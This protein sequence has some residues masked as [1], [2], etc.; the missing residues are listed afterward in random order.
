MLPPTGYIFGADR[1]PNSKHKVHIY[2]GSFNN[3]GLPMCRK[4]WNRDNG[5]SYSIL[6]GRFD[7]GSGIC[8]TCYKR[9]TKG[10]DGIV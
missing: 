2:K 9:A 4:G 5:E 6:R 8:K 10:L 3:P 1:T 7:L